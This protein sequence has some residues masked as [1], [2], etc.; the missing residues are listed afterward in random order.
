[1]EIANSNLIQIYSYIYEDSIYY[2]MK[3]VN[4]IIDLVNLLKYSPYM[5][6]KIPEFND[7]SRRELI[8]KSYRIMYNIEYDKIYI[9]RI[10]HSARKL[11]KQLIS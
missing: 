8:Y 4:N 10:W 2:A 11:P 1:M 5:W 9:R 7:E 6:R 3:T